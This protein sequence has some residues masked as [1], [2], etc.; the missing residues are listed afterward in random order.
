MKR[1]LAVLAASAFFC[2]L[3]FAQQA[4]PPSVG[5]SPEPKSTTSRMTVETAGPIVDQLK[6]IEDEWT[7]A[8]L[9]KDKAAIARIEAEDYTFI[10]PSGHIAN[11]QEDLKSM[12][13]LNFTSMSTEDVSYRSYGDAAIVTGI[14]R[15][16]GTEK[17]KDISGD[18]RFT[19]V[20]ANRNGQWQ[21]VS[22]QLTRIVPPAATA[23]AQR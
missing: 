6:K 17:G 21:A 7:K 15:V 22:S 12:D 8:L 10:D 11:K 2:V 9:N 1:R 20:F 3:V 13:D 19:D 16:K 5:A 23:E 4:Q 14:A 18:Y